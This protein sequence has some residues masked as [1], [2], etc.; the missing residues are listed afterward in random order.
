MNSDN[1]D[2]NDNNSRYISHEEIYQ[3]L[4]RLLTEIQTLSERIEILLRDL[5]Y[6]V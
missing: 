5:G 3:E 6:C 2:N 1:N 4:Q